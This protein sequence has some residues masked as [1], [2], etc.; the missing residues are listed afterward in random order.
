MDW[1]EQTKRQA[2]IDE[3]S[4]AFDGVRRGNGITLHQARVLDDYWE[5]A[6]KEAEARAED[7]DTRWQDVPDAWMEEF[8][9]DLPFINDP[10]GF[11]YYIPAFMIWTL[12]YYTSSDS[13]VTS[14]VA[15][16]LGY[17]PSDPDRLRRYSLLTNEQRRAVAHFLAFYW[18]NAE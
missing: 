2:L 6:E 14:A 13:V 10:E 1:G 17:R 11:R 4:H 8:G 16:T 9:D 12:K 15:E 5:D 7:T 18:D 3:I